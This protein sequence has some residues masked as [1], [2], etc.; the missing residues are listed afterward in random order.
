MLGHG[1]GPLLMT[2]GRLFTENTRDILLWVSW[3][4]TAQNWQTF[5]LSYQHNRL[6]KDTASYHF[7]LVS[8]LACNR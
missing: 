6:V 5:S 8:F 1:K 3:D 2:G 7:L 4:G